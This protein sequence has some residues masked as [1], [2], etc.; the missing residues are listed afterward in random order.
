MREEV[1]DELKSIS[2][3]SA[4]LICCIVILSVLVPTQLNI[5][6]QKGYDFYRDDV[7][8]SRDD[9]NIHKDTYKIDANNKCVYVYNK[10]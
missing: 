3:I 2:I 7:V 6:N 8:I 4:I 9:F 5:A 1:L 10:P